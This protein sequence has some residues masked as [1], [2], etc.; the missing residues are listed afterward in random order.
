MP[1]DD[2]EQARAEAL[3]LAALLAEREA[4][5]AAA[6]TARESHEHALVT[7]RGALDAAGG[8]LA[9]RDAELRDARNAISGLRAENRRLDGALAAQE[10]IIAYRQGIRWWLQLPWLRA[11]LWWQRLRDQ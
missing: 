10:R 3:R 9:D 8:A 11:R 4:Q 7:A 1:A 6:N 5:L 2:I